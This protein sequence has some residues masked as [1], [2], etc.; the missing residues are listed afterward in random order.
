MAGV[1]ARLLRAMDVAEGGAAAVRAGTALVLFPDG[2]AVA[3]DPPFPATDVPEIAGCGR[4]DARAG[5]TD[6][7]GP[8]PL[9]VPPVLVGVPDDAV[10]VRGAGVTREGLAMLLD[11]AVVVD[12][13]PRAAF[14]A[15]LCMPDQAVVPSDEPVRASPGPSTWL[16][17]E[18]TG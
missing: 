13:F 12:C 3:P 2:D 14:P 4:A 16:A 9:L 17:S 18:V 7:A 5:I 10:P 6:P 8:V 1:A 11:G 15:R